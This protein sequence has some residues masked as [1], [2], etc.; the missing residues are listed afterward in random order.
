MIN[1]KIVRLWSFLKFA[2]VWCY[3]DLPLEFSYKKIF[4]DCWHY[5]LQI[6]FIV[7]GISY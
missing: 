5:K 2:R 1:I 6:G 7:F 4:H 3:L